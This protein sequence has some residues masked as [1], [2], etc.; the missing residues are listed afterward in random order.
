[1]MLNTQQNLDF[2]MQ[3]ALVSHRVG[4][5]KNKSTM[6]ILHYNTTLLFYKRWPH[7]T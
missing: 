1:M 7:V 3:G 4:V 5:E 2:S 6:H